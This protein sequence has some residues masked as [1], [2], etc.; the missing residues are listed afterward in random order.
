MNRLIHPHRVALPAAVALCLAVALAGCVSPA[1]KDRVA[2]L[3]L[4]AMT[5]LAQSY[6]QDLAALRSL[7]GALLAVESESRRTDLETAI[8]GAYLTAS[9]DADLDA[10]HAN[11]QAPA[12]A[13]A[14]DPLVAEVRAGGM[15]PDRARDWLSDYALAWRMNAGVDVRANLINQFAPIAQQQ[16][17]RSTLLGALDAHRDAVTRVFADAIASAGSLAQA[18]ALQREF[19]QPAQGV[20]STL[21]RQRILANVHDPASRQLLTSVLAGFAPDLISDSSSKDTP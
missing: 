12:S 6:A 21:W 18:E 10:L 14:V 13:V 17:A 4:D 1:S 16:A 9:G 7:A 3:Q 5:K 8:V 20:F 19:V 15:T 11:L 2:Q